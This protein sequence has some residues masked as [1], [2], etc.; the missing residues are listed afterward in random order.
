MAIVMIT[1][2]REITRTKEI[3]RTRAMINLIKNQM[4]S[5]RKMTSLKNIMNDDHK[6]T[7]D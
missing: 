2:I 7:L 4:E 6:L 5:N 1:R 3:I